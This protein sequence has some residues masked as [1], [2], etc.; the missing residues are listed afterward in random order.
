MVGGRKQA[1][2]RMAKEGGPARL[3]WRGRTSTCWRRSSCVGL[4]FMSHLITLWGT[5]RELVCYGSTIASI[6]MTIDRMHHGRK[7]V[8]VKVG[9]DQ[10][11]SFY[12]LWD[13]FAWT[14]I[15]QEHDE[16]VGCI[17]EGA[18]LVLLEECD[19]DT[20]HSNI[21]GVCSNIILGGLMVGHIWNLPF[22][23][24]RRK[25]QVAMA[26]LQN[27]NGRIHKGTININL[28]CEVW[29]IGCL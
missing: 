12:V 19:E 6:M 13:L 9:F 18:V 28:L 3:V 20:L 29:H 4:C 25:H 24:G 14:G 26:N 15:E 7:K 2:A 11:W 5:N 27:H 16:C 21:A 10:A 23:R 17:E 8:W 1:G 22:Q